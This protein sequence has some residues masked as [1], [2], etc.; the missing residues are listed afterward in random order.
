MGGAVKYDGNTFTNYTVK[1]GLSNNDV[2][3][4]FTDKAGNI[5]FAYREGGITRYDDK[6]TFTHFAEKERDWEGNSVSC[7]TEDK[8]GNLWFGTKKG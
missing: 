4:I 8:S 7:I 5:W 6:K 1:E 2:R 3:L